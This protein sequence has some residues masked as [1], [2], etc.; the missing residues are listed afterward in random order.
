MEGCLYR[1]CVSIFPGCG[2]TGGVAPR[3]NLHRARLAPRLAEDG[4]EGKPRPMGSGLGKR[5]DESHIRLVSQAQKIGALRAPVIRTI[6]VSQ[7]K[8]A[9]GIH[10]NNSIRHGIVSG[11]CRFRPRL[12]GAV[13]AV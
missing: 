13:E 7:A 1:G 12:D 9:D 2:V 4:R 10:G 8:V 3:D 11:G 6:G 5:R